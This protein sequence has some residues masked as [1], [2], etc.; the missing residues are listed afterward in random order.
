MDEFH[1]MLEGLGLETRH[2]RLDSVGDRD[3]EIEI[4]YVGNRSM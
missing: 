1:E 3:A 4:A 2:S